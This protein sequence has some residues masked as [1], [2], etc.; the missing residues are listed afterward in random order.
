MLFLSLSSLFPAVSHFQEEK[1]QER[2][3]EMRLNSQE[4][5]LY[6]CISQRT[7]TRVNISYTYK[8]SLFFF[9]KS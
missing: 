6:L 8:T 5:G 7:I 3:R 4:Y 9:L 1:K 2:V